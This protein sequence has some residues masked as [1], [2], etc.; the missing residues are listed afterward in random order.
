M[1]KISSIVNRKQ[2]QQQRKNTHC[3]IYQQENAEKYNVSRNKDD[4][5]CVG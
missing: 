4:K 5:N 2:Q 3:L 1:A